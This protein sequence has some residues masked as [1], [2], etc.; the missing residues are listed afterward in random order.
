M[1]YSTAASAYKATSQT[2]LASKTKQVIML[3][4][5]ILAA[6]QKAEQAIKDNNI[7][8]R[9]NNLTKA[10]DIIYGL[11]LS[12]DMDK[13]G[14]IASLLYDYYA[15][16]DMRLMS[17]HQSNDAEMLRHC[18]KH[19]KM[20]REAWVDVDEEQQSTSQ[21]DNSSATEDAILKPALERS[22]SDNYE[23]PKNAESVSFSV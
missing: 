4:D 19:V 13:G 20:M 2:T 7:Q 21:P 17:V 1:N 15:G 18:I 16:L 10:C 3:Y 22:A 8:E 11:Q 9:Y 23:P 6:I 14:E 12:L 5:G